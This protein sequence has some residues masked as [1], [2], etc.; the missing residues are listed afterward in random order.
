M[1]KFIVGTDWW[2]D[3][4]DAVA[5]RIL[6][7]AVKN[8]NI[9]IE[10]IGINACMEYSC[11]SL[12]AFLKSEGIKDISLGIDSQA[13]D[14][15]GRPPY[16]KRL[17]GLLN[18][19]IRNDMF[20]D[21]AELY[22]SVLKSAKEKLEVIEIGYPQVLASV[23]KAEPELF[24]EK[25]SK[26]WMMAG[27]WDDNPGKENNFSRNIRASKAA[28]EFCAL[29]PVPVVFLGWE[30]ADDIITGGVLNEDDVLK[31][32]LNDHG[33]P[34]G[35]SSWD[36]LLV[37]TAIENN[38]ERSGFDYVTGRAEV[39]PVTGE[40]MFYPSHD[41]QHCYLV[42]KLPNSFYRSKINGLIV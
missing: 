10:C 35:R 33:S 6:C 28:A 9:G 5:M 15:Y 24:A 17:A 36:P 11:A 25:V 1:R 31:K 7:R 39:D 2:T 12:Y 14:F 20:P 8:G 16:Q 29:C 27:K 23:I 13:V 32:V 26:V 18:E 19:T 38:L 42:K 40:N 34:E 37:C 41:G 3:C 22:I 21:A 4:D 30:I